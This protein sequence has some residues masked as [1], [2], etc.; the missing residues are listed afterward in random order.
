VRGGVEEASLDK[1]SAL[2]SLHC[3]DTDGWVTAG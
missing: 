2:Y 3:F 1:V